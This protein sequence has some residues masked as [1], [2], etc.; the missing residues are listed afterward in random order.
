MH[1]LNIYR[2]FPIEW[3]QYSEYLTAGEQEHLKKVEDKILQLRIQQFNEISEKCTF[4]P[5][6]ND[7]RKYLSNSPNKK[8]IRNKPLKN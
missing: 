3:Y 8:I 6:V 2:I 4:N 7:Y 1:P 5:K